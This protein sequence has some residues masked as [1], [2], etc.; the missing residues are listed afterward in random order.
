MSAKPRR[1]RGSGTFGQ[2]KARVW[3]V[4]EY[5]VNLVEDETADHETRLKGATTLVQAALAYARVVELYDLE[6]EVKGLEQ[7]AQRNGHAA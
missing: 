1:R 5:T 3:A 7:L 2:L 6:R 4:L